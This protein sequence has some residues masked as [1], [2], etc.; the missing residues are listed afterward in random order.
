MAFDR[1][2]VL[3]LKR[4]TNPPELDDAAADA[5]QDEHLA[6]LSS[7]HEG[8]QLA[9]AGP[10]VDEHESLRGICLFT[11]TPEE[12]RALA[13]RDPKVKQGVLEIEVLPWMVPAGAMTF[14][15]AAFPR[16]VAEADSD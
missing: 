12:A 2:T 16:S 13:E 9:V 4:G 11:V 5:L 10:I 15:R 14:A 6:F 8:G 3:F 7:L 1:L